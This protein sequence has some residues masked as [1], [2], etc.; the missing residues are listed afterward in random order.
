MTKTKHG[1]SWIQRHIQDP[2]VKQAQNQGYRSRASFKLLE[3][4][5]KDRLFKPG[6]HVVDLGA[7]PGGW[8]QV[9]SKLIG[10]QGK[11]IALD[12]LPIQPM[13][14]VTVLEGDFSADETLL[15]LEQSL[16]GLP[17]DWVLSDMSPNISGIM[18]ADQPRIMLLA[19][20]ALEFAKA[21]LKPK[22]G[23]LVKVFQGEGFDL[24]IKTLRQF[25]D[26]VVI[27]KPPASRS[28]SRELYVLARGYYNILEPF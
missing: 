22:G 8:S 28:S 19:E 24:F 7:A 14:G 27:R 18:A 15:I 3:L 5:E 17:L 26:Q 25:F 10:K 11:V 6:M 1:K 21:H 20:M 4:H 23:L 9:V 16:N 13:Q 2:Y 12:L